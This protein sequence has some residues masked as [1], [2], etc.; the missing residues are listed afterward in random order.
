MEFKFWFYKSV[1][2][3]QPWNIS[4]KVSWGM[5]TKH[6][7][8]PSVHQSKP[9]WNRNTE[10]NVQEPS[11]V[12]KFEHIWTT[13][14]IDE[15]RG[16]GDWGKCELICQGRYGHVGLC[17]GWGMRKQLVELVAEGG[18]DEWQAG[19]RQGGFQWCK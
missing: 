5:C 11:D 12:M 17:G 2:W 15:D 9:V 1:S 18:L 13:E 14:W 6:I 19:Q 10:I 3:I 16:K 7:Q 4:L 8:C